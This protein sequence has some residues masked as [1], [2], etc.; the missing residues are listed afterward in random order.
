MPLSD[1]A[2]PSKTAKKLE[3]YS[4][5]GPIKATVGK[6]GH[7]TRKNLSINH[8]DFLTIRPVS[9]RPTRTTSRTS[10]SEEIQ[11]NGTSSRRPK[12]SHVSR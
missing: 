6:C 11:S 1:A 2:V 8:L 7:M 5:E 10:F 9:S 3:N 4:K 12:T